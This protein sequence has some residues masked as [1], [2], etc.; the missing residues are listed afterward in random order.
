[1]V[2]LIQQVKSIMNQNGAGNK[3]LW[4][5][6]AGWYAPKPFPSQELAA[7][8][9]ARAYVVNWLA[10]VSR[11][12]WY[13]WDNHNWT[14]LELTMPDNTTL[15]PAGKAFG[16]IEQWMVGA[17]MTKCLISPNNDWVC[18]L[19]R[20]GSSQF[21]V[22]NTSG[23]HDFRLSKDWRVSQYT[24]LDGT[25][26]KISGDSLTVGVQPVLIQ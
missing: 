15:R 16:T 18:E 14:T 26:S 25:V 3:P 5:T 17:S 11:F 12:Y 24:K 7:A 13:C 22:W 8:Y 6:E 4:N 9:V 23:N 20:N 10:G 2:P 21:I 1:M 19:K